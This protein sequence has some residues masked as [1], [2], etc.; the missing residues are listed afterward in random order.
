MRGVV[1]ASLMALGLAACARPQPDL[2]AERTAVMQASRDWAKVAATGDLERI[3]SFWSDDAIVLPPD[4]PAVVGKD[5]LR[6]MVAEMS[7]IPGFSITWEP[8]RAWIA[9]SGDVAYLVERS[10]I[11]LPD[12]TGAARSMFAKG[13]TVWRKDT[14]GAWKCVVDTW[15]GNPTEQALPSEG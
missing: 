11:T 9:A 2:E 15:N 6:A 10:R 5:A 4:Q 3:L 14:T 8:E 12:S 13:V 7:A 1:V